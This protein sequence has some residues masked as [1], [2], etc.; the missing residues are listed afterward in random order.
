MASNR[1]NAL[2]EIARRFEEE[3]G[4]LS[5]AVTAFPENEYAARM[6]AAIRSGEVPTLFM[7]DFLGGGIGEV[8]APLDILLNSLSKDNYLL[9]PDY[10]R[11]FPSKREIPTGLSVAV[12]YGNRNATGAD[13]PPFPEAVTDWRQFINLPYMFSVGRNGLGSVLAQYTGVSVQSGAIIFPEDMADK[14]VQL[15]Q[16]ARIKLSEGPLDMLKNDKLVFLADNTSIIG[17]VQE[18]L[19]GHYEVIPLCEESRLIASVADCWA[20]SNSATKNQQN[21]A[22]L[23][24]RFLL[25]TYAQDRLYLQGETAI[26]LNKVILEQFIQSNPDLAFLGTGLF[27]SA[28]EYDRLLCQFGAD[29]YDDLLM[30]A[31]TEDAIR[32][33]I[34]SHRK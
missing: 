8:T 33:F 29:V 14:L 26:P 3:N 16:A 6:S 18:A 20:V 25:E 5:L 22:M 12:L 4:Q 19:A 7:T 1:L 24:V 30:K 21:A 31:I 11:L 9:L 13:G 10:E 32:D 2:N 27:A 15:K 28:G 23:F 34:V 17:S